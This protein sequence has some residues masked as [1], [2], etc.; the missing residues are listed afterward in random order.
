MSYWAVCYQILFNFQEFRYFDIK[1]EY[2]GLTSE[3]MTAPEGNIRISVNEEASS[4]TGQ[5]EEVL[6]ACNGEGIQHKRDEGLGEGNFKALFES[7]EQDQVRR[8]V[9]G[10]DDAC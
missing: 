3:A 10:A 9:V 8:D 4:S 5:V 1:G 2:T 6:M 7:I